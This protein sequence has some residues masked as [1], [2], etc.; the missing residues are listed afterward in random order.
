MKNL[1][2]SLTAVVA[3]AI[4][5]APCSPAQSMDDL[6]L[7]V[8]G[9]ATQGFI[10][11]NHNSWDTT[12]SA[13]GSPAWTE[14]VVNLSMQP[15]PKLRIGVQARYYILGD[16]GDQIVLDWAQVDYKVNERFGFRVGDVKTPIGLLNETQDIDPAHL[17]VL[18]PQSIYPIASRSSLLDH[19]GGVL[20]G[21]VPL[22]ERLGKL[23]YRAFGGQR[24][25]GS[26]DPC[27]DVLTNEGINL[28][29]GLTGKTF[30]G[31]L[32]WNTPLPGLTFGVSENSGATSAEAT[33]GS[34]QGTIHGA[35]FRQLFYFGKYERNK[36]MVAG[37]YSREQTLGSLQLTGLPT[38]YQAGD[39]RPFYGMASYKLTAKLTGGLY[40]SSFI[41]R[42][43]AFTS[44]RY[45]KDWAVA[46][47]YDFSPFVYAKVEQH[48]VDGAAVGFSASDNPN[49][50]PTTRM[51]LLKLGVSF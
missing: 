27:F 37:E 43:A 28:P 38:I 39:K 29:N 12:D 20:Y 10:Y 49:L 11:T 25:I 13:S 5:G 35:Q 8:H 17:W 44:Y 50:Q 15:Q 19:Y 1:L 3:I 18:L 34:L 21:T 14:A 6:N 2:T 41:D 42:K 36:W 47:R 32:R 7:Q 23:E 48:F 46:A 30:G 9:Y 45:Q 24:I 4:F 51:T 16:Y 22:G 33:L 26:K 40:Y 31:T